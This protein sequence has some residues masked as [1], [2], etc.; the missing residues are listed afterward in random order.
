MSFELVVCGSAGTHPGPGRACSGYLLRTAGTRVMLD[1]GNGSTAL[2][3]QETAIEDLDA[4]VVSH[5]HHDHWADLIGVYYALRFHPDGQRS[6]DVYA[7]PGTR[8]FVAQ[9]LSDDAAAVF[10]EVCIFHDIAAGDALTIGDLA[11]SFTHSEHV[12]PTVSVRAEHDGEV[13]AYSSDSAGGPELIETARDADIFLCEASWV[14][15][16][17]DWPD[18]V[19][20]T[21]GGAG[22]HARAAGVGR[23]LLTH[24]WPGNDR[25]VARWEAADAFGDGPL[26]LVDDGQIW[27]VGAAG[28]ER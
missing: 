11:L 27:Q 17:E 8:E 12:V 3:Q 16:R 20:L 24:L 26:H 23:L 15:D 9:L 25:E 6:I 7:P 4:V 13:L 10:D 1:C 19:H 21:A 2:M 18:G 5:R 14:G 28:S 22:E